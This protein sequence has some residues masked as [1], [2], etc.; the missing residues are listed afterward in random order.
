MLNDDNQNGEAEVAQGA[1]P[2]IPAAN[3]PDPAALREAVINIRPDAVVSLLAA[4]PDFMTRQDFAFPTSEDFNAT[5]G[6]WA[7]KRLELV[8]GALSIGR[9]LLDKRYPLEEEDFRTIGEFLISQRGLRRSGST[10]LSRCLVGLSYLDE[11]ADLR[12]NSNATL[13]QLLLKELDETRHTMDM[14]SYMELWEFSRTETY[15]RLPYMLRDLCAWK[16]CDEMSDK[17]FRADSRWKYRPNLRR[18]RR[19]RSQALANRDE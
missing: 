17:F 16:L 14:V 6:Q 13:R 8:A 19:S 11:H 15:L 1:D 5:N 10:A 2:A 18:S 9:S 7:G 4:F 3:E 12:V